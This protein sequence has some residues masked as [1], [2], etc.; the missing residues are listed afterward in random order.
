MCTNVYDAL[1]V[2]ENMD[3]SLQ[4]RTCENIHPVK[5]DF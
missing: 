3:S 2:Y 4:Q 1:K 5:T